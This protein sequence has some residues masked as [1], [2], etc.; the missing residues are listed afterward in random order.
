MP[1]VLSCRPPASISRRGTQLDLEPRPYR[2]CRPSRGPLPSLLQMPLAPAAAKQKK[3]KKKSHRPGR[4]LEVVGI[5]SPA[6][7]LGPDSLEPEP[8][9]RSWWSAAWR[10]PR[11]DEAA[12]FL[13]FSPGSPP[14]WSALARALATS[15]L[16]WATSA[17]RLPL[18]PG[19]GLGRS[20]P[21]ALGPTPPAMARRSSRFADRPQLPASFLGPRR[22]NLCRRPPCPAAFQ[23]VPRRTRPSCAIPPS[24]GLPPS[25][26]RSKLLGCPPR[27]AQAQASVG[28]SCSPVESARC[29]SDSFP[30]GCGAGAW[31][32]LPSRAGGPTAC[33]SQVA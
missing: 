30:W 24:G 17:L 5:S 18:T 12:L 33:R 21:R 16:R 10:C 2:P 20:G 27:E 4:L 15:P 3:T 28:R 9:S 32:D 1:L 31:P 19:T 6:P 14:R 13:Y 29:A 8:T 7:A 23:L 11:L 22:G 26:S 25:A